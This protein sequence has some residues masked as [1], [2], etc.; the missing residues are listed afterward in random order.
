M[1]IFSDWTH[2][3]EAALPGRQE[4]FLTEG[5]NEMMVSI[6]GKGALQILKQLA[7]AGCHLAPMPT[8]NGM[9]A[10]MFSVV[11][12]TNVPATQV[13]FGLGENGRGEFFINANVSIPNARD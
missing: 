8:P 6:E 10:S 4:F 9:L 11:G 2:A 12:G 13:C 1:G 5:K 3:I 7:D